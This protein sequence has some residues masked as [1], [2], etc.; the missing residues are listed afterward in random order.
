MSHV[1]LFATT[2]LLSILMSSNYEGVT[3]SLTRGKHYLF[4]DKVDDLM[5]IDNVNV[6]TDGC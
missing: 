1:T 3:C 2:K 6:V 5:E 4:I